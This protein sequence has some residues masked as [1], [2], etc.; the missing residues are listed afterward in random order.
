M[1]AQMDFEK[2]RFNMVEQQIRPWDVL[3]QQVLDLLFRGAA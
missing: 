2:A 1:I 3:D